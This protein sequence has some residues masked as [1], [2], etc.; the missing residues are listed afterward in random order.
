M[1]DP[2]SDPCPAVIVMGVAGSGK[3][4]LARALAG[5]L[6]RAFIEGDDFHSKGNKAKMAAGLPLD[7]DDRRDWIAA[8]TGAIRARGEPCIVSCSALNSV[9]RD[10]IAGGL[11]HA[12][13]Y[14]LLH[15]PAALLDERLRARTGHYFGPALLGSQLAALDPPPGA[16]RIDIALPADEQLSVALKALD[17]K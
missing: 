1:P 3:T 17:E 7:N 2:S 4:T 13:L 14:I 11:G 5:H 9:V 6:H 12:P 15:G 8:L 10:W 16:V